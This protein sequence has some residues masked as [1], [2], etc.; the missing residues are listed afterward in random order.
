MPYLLI[1]LFLLSVWLILSANHARLFVGGSYHLAIHDNRKPRAQR[2]IADH[3]CWLHDNLRQAPSMHTAPLGEFLMSWGKLPY[4]NGGNLQSAAR[5]TQ[6]SLITWR[7]RVHGCHIT[8]RLS[9][10]TKLNHAHIRVSNFS[11]NT[12]GQTRF[13]PMLGSTQP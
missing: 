2:L 13:H 12:A 8:D 6:L 7:L 11:T 10:L 3:G 9:V 1:R 4:S 5:R